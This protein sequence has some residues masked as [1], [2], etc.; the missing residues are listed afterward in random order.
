MPTL[1]AATEPDLPGGMYIGPGGPG[2]MWG[3]PVPVGL[4]RGVARS[5]RATPPLGALRGADRRAVPAVSQSLLTPRVKF[6]GMI[7]SSRD[8]SW[9]EFFPSPSSASSMPL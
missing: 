8:S 6:S 1:Y 7:R 9:I 5:R 4:Q 2:E 3:A